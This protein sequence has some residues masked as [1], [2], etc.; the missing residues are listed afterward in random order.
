MPS[1]TSKPQW[2]F[3]ISPLRE[4]PFS[5]Y[6]SDIIFLDCLTFGAASI[7]CSL[8]PFQSSIKHPENFRRAENTPA[9][10][11]EAQEILIIE[12]AL[13]MKIFHDASY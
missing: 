13:Q 4:I 11:K 7:F 12:A 6:M 1:Y 8:P 10:W 2:D 3:A 9:T 5:R